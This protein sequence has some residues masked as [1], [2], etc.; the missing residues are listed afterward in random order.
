V[1]HLRVN[2]EHVPGQGGVESCF[3]FLAVMDWMLAVVKSSSHGPVVY[4][5][6]AED[7]V[8]VSETVLV[9]LVLVLVVLLLDSG[10][11][12]GVCST[13]RWTE[14]RLQVHNSYVL[15]PGPTAY[16]LRPPRRPEP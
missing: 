8:E 15:R 6:H 1:S 11:Q 5:V 4:P 14:V 12:G 13:A 10:S 16:C 3:V 7:N 2:E 9:V